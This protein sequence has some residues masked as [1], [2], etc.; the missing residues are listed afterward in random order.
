M[1]WEH[2]SMEWLK[3]AVIWF[4][5]SAIYYLCWVR[6]PPKESR[7]SPVNAPLRRE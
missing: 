3:V 7:S 2:W 6:Y 1:D 4:S 5:T